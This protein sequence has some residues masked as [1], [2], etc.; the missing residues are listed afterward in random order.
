MA[1]LFASNRQSGVLDRL[2]IRRDCTASDD[3]AAAEGGC[4]VSFTGTALLPGSGP[5]LQHLKLPRKIVLADAMRALE[6][7]S[8]ERQ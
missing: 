6:K 5:R 1:L 4:T 7:R 8:Q 2:V 3:C